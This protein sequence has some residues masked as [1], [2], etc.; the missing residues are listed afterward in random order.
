MGQETTCEVGGVPFVHFSEEKD[1]IIKQL[2]NSPFDCNYLHKEPEQAVS[3]ILEQ[4]YRQLCSLK[5]RQQKYLR[6]I[7]RLEK[8]ISWIEDYRSQC[9]P[10]DPPITDKKCRNNHRAMR[11]H[12]YEKSVYWNCQNCFCK[13][14]IKDGILHCGKDL[15]NGCKF[16]WCIECGTS[17]RLTLKRIGPRFEPD[18][19]QRLTTHDSYEVIGAVKGDII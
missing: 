10:N 4:L 15:G 5:N 17:N 13:V 8:D 19:W 3:S 1:P 11:V 7:K 16:L 14:R 6:L 9:R 2:T 12:K 18:Y